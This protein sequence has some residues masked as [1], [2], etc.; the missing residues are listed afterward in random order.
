MALVRSQWNPLAISSEEQA[1][2][3]KKKEERH[4]KKYWQRKARNSGSQCR[5]KR[6]EDR[7]L[8]KNVTK[9]AEIE[10]NQLEVITV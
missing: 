6:E 5:R 3:W 10:G 8:P 7:R 4:I 1:H 2:K 9:Q